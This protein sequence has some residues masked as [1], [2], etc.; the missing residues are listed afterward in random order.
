MIDKEIIS[1]FTS[2]SEP[3]KLSGGQ[4]ESYKVNG[5]SPDRVGKFQGIS[6]NIQVRIL[7][8]KYS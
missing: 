8:R 3:I 4:N 6:G 2:L 1:S 5:S 7:R